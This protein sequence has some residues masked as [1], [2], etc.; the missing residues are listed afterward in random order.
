MLPADE[1]SQTAALR[2]PIEMFRAAT[3]DCCLAWADALRLAGWTVTVTDRDDLTALK[4]DL[5]VP[6]AIRSCHTSLVAG[7]IV[8]GH[9]P[10]AAIED[11]LRLK[12]AI[13]GIALPG[14]PA[15]SP[16]MPGVIEG[17]LE[18][19]AWGGANQPALFGAY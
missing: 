6:P 16:G 14:M 12:P 19:L 13:A 17:R 3:C 9:V 10:P 7:Y 11:L 2:P 5:G 18:V 1:P 4:D 15:G 8:E